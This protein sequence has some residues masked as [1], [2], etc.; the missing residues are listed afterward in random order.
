MAP[1]P[2]VEFQPWNWISILTLAFMSHE[3]I[4]KAILREFPYTPTSDQ[5]QLINLLGRFITD[6][7]SASVFVL[8]GYAGTGKT[9]IVSSLVKILPSLRASSVLLAPTGRAAKVLASYS[10]KQAF[11]IHKKIYRLLPSV[12]GSINVVLQQNKHKNTFFIVDEASMIGGSRS[13]QAELFGGTNLLDDLIH[14]VN[15]GVN[16]RLILIGDTA[17]LPPVMT[18]ESPAL[19]EKFL[20]QRYHLKL[21][22][23]ELK[24]VV[25]QARDSSIL[26][27]ATLIRQMLGK[28]EEGFP[29]LQLTGFNDFKRLEGPDAADEVNNAFMG[30]EIEE[31]LIVCRSNKRAN[32]FNQHIRSKV[33]F[34]EDEIS[35]GDLLMVVKNN[36][37]WLPDSSNAG[38]IANGDIMELKRIRRIEDLY[39]FRFADVTA[40]MLDYPNE[41]DLEVKILLDTLN[42]EGPS[43]SNADSKKLFEE[44]AADYADIP[45][46]GTRLARIKNNPHYNALQVKFAYAL[47][48]H[49][50]QGGQWSNVFVEMGYIP[51][52]EPDTEYL[53]WLYTALTRATEKIFLLNFT[54]DFFE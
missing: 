52:K 43:L 44:V 6:G 16:C 42:A 25:R 53:R 7:D 2:K 26:H 40:R 15:D 17:Q 34:R 5:S 4:S 49:K 35:A 3:T 46:K 12:D 37:F 47:T 54:D 28:K 51:N 27:N 22:S 32:L 1:P 20:S 41:P 48:C 23:F 14:F 45:N 9:T 33:L 18:T 19:N 38:F 11:T 8:K 10:G 39:G 31:T 29:K 50:A 30:R 21:W 36:Y 13:E 24:E